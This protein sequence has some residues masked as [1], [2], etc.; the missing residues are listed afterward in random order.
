MNL[1]FR[2]IKFGTR[3]PNN[4]YL[5]KLSEVRSTSCKFTSFLASYVYHCHRFKKDSNR[6]TKLHLFY[7]TRVSISCI[8]LAT[9]FCNFSLLAVAMWMKCD[10]AFLFVQLGDVPSRFLQHKLHA[11]NTC[12]EIK[13]NIIS[14]A[15]HYILYAASW[16]S[17]VAQ[18]LLHIVNVCRIPPLPPNYYMWCSNGLSGVRFSHQG[19]S[20]RR[21]KY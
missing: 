20:R 6:F 10:L 19:W 7:S 13:W 1:S 3:Q 17:G 5:A 11:W 2:I 15:Q 18:W 16:R 9:V 12:N 4:A 8:H 14:S 21:P